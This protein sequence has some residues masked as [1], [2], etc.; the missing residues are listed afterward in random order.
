V[1]AAGACASPT[2]PLG[3]VVTVTNLATGATATCTIEGRGPFGGGDR[4]I[5]LDQATFAR[6]AP[7]AEGVIDVRISW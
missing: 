1:A 6:L 4:I 7:L 2:L 3:T 5:D